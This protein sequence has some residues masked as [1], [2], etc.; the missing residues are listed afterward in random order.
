MKNSIKHFTD[1]FDQYMAERDADTVVPGGRGWSGGLDGV[2]GCVGHAGPGHCCD[3]AGEL[4]V[5]V[6]FLAQFLNLLC[7]RAG[8]EVPGGQAGDAIPGRGPGPG[9]AFSPG[10]ARCGGVGGVAARPTSV[11]VAA[12]AVSRIQLIPQGPGTAARS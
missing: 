10:A 7:F 2:G 4:G 6:I 3:R 11:P 12:V 8:C 1:H 9:Q 5:G